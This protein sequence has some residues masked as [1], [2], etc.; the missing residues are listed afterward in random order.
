MKRTK[1]GFVVISAGFFR[2]AQTKNLYTVRP[3]FYTIEECT[4]EI[5]KE[6]D[7]RLFMPDRACVLIPKV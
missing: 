2:D 3:G 6:G 7:K 4:A 1:S 5:N